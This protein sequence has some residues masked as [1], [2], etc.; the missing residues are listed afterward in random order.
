MA[1]KDFFLREAGIGK[2]FKLKLDSTE[3]AGRIIALDEEALMLRKKD[4]KTA[5]VALSTLTFYE[6]LPPEVDGGEVFSSPNLKP[7]NA[8]IGD[9]AA[10]PAVQD[11]D[12]IIEFLIK[13]GDT[14]FSKVSAPAVRSFD[15]MGKLLQGSKAKS[16]KELVNMVNSIN[17]AIATENTP[18]GYN[19]SKNLDKLKKLSKTYPNELY[20]Y[21]FLGALYAHCRYWSEA[22]KYYEKGDDYESAFA[23]A[24]KAHDE[25]KKLVFASN[26]LAFDNILNPYIIKYIAER[27]LK[28][29]DFS[30]L[31]CMSERDTK[32]GSLQGWIALVRL[33]LQG[34]GI[35]S[36]SFS[37]PTSW[38]TLEELLNIC[39]S[40]V[41]SESSGFFDLVKSKFE[42]LEAEA[43]RVKAI[44][45]ADDYFLEAVNAS[46]EKKDDEA[47]ELYLKA[48]ESGHRVGSAAT[49]LALLY[50]KNGRHNDALQVLSSNRSE[51]EPDKYDNTLK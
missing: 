43:A 28:E 37:E 44:E 13:N 32:S 6:E 42:K 30:L 21:N 16:V 46:A 41:K 17:S 26:H 31:S 36:Y 39:S 27:M 7:D 48:I 34:S 5:A 10:Y 35:S 18:N 23:V 51:I 9:T 4:G 19:I 20:S 22:L 33:I 38:S 3:V 50:S 1:I 25:E 24:D 2:Y 49:N 29:K 45:S 11:I 40:S 15:A 14:F 8:E 12:S 47:I